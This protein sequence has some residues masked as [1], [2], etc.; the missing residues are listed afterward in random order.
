MGAKMVR[1][2]LNKAAIAAVAL[3]LTAS[4]ASAQECPWWD[5]TCVYTIDPPP[6]DPLPEPLPP[7][8]RSDDP[9]PPV[10]LRSYK[11]EGCTVV[12]ENPL[13]ISYKDANGAWAT[14]TPKCVDSVPTIYADGSVKYNDID[15]YKGDHY[16][17][18]VCADAPSDAPTLKNG[19]MI[20]TQCPANMFCAG[21]EC[22]PPQKVDGCWDSDQVGLSDPKAFMAEFLQLN[23]QIK[24]PGF[25]KYHNPYFDISKP[26]DAKLNPKFKFWV[27]DCKSPQFLNEQSCVTATNN[28]YFSEPKQTTVSCPMGTECQVVAITPAQDITNDA[29]KDPFQPLKT[30]RCMPKP[31][32]CEPPFI[33]ACP[34]LPGCQF[35]KLECPPDPDVCKNIPESD[36]KKKYPASTIFQA[37][38]G[39]WHVDQC[40]SPKQV[41]H[42]FCLGGKADEAITSCPSDTSCANGLCNGQPAP[43]PQ[44]KPADCEDSDITDSNPYGD[45]KIA[46]TIKIKGKWASGDMCKSK[47]IVQQ[48]KCDAKIDVGFS[49][50]SYTCASKDECCDGACFTLIAPQCGDYTDTVSSK[51]GVKGTSKQ[52]TVFD[53]K[54]TCSNDLLAKAACD[55]TGCLGYQFKIEAC[56][57]GKVCQDGLCV[58]KQDPCSASC[59]ALADG[60]EYINT[61]DPLC[62]KMT[63]KNF[64]DAEFLTTYTCGPDSKPVPTLIKCPSGLCDVNKCVDC[65]EVSDIENDLKVKGEVKSTTGNAL[66]FCTNDG[67]VVQVQCL[68]GKYNELA[69]ADCPATDYCLQGV[70]LPKP[71]QCQNDADCTDANVCTMEACVAGKCEQTGQKGIPEETACEKF[72]CN[73]QTGAIESTNQDKCIS[74][75]VCDAS[76]KCV[77]PDPCAGKFVDDYNACTIDKCTNG[78]VTNTQLPVDDGDLCTIDTCVAGMVKNTPMSV[79][80]FDPCT[81]DSCVNGVVKNI[82]SP[83]PVCQDKDNDGIPNDNDNCP[84]V[85]NKTQEDVNT[86]KVG[87]ACELQLTARNVHACATFFATNPTTNATQPQLKCW[88]YNGS[89]QV[90]N[91]KTSLYVAPAAT[92]IDSYGKPVF[93]TSIA[94]GY[95]HSC[96][97]SVKGTSLP[98]RPLCWGSSNLYA[99]GNINGNNLSIATPIPVGMGNASNMGVAAGTSASCALNS[100]GYVYC[101][102]LIIEQQKKNSWAATWMPDYVMSGPNTDLNNV[103]SIAAGGKEICAV[104]KDGT[105]RCWGMTGTQA[106]DTPVTTHYPKPITKPNS[107]TGP[108]T[109]ILKIATSGDHA[110]VLLQDTSVVCWGRATEG[111]L[112]TSQANLYQNTSGLWYG[113][114][115]FVVMDPSAYVSLALTGAVDIAVGQKHSCAVLKNG[116]VTCWGGNASGEL[117]GSPVGGPFGPLTPVAVEGVSGVTQIA[118]GANFTCA[119]VK[120]QSVKCWGNNQFGQLG[121]PPPPACG[122]KQIEADE[123]CDDGNTLSGDGCSSTCQL[124]EVKPVCGNSK[125][126]Y[127]EECDDGNTWGGDGCSAL[128]KKEIPVDPYNPSND[129]YGNP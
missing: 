17:K 46:G 129:P 122:N 19:Q 128:C 74:P 75:L 41:W 119:R 93:A 127:P 97:I 29:A 96:A 9:T 1:V 86:N 43:E 90:G 89:G 61:A 50:K 31:D 103:V 123:V 114:P 98:P 18:P 13:T 82:P 47:K 10:D 33:D 40:A 52:G 78:I 81:T 79:D 48:D 69:P 25:A 113:Y 22:K 87:D 5:Y 58:K 44:D 115:Y 63:T 99:N 77:L 108:M 106:G 53:I 104:L 67:K 30:A 102:G 101:W 125:I 111:Q 95:N 45:L 55:L 71:P 66:D 7:D 84:T 16:L 59:T 21:G 34:T 65:L 42:L 68:N 118:A 23:P 35:T 64:C 73:S 107:L 110:C 15:D 85:Y 14:A 8:A 92:V 70:C 100:D 37:N 20:L 109:G 6:V 112:G 12:A 57:D 24:I 76:K 51:H 38:G 126:E 2:F 26:E 28:L 72:S 124:E 88:G 39:G 32:A 83:D 91:G 94:A 27:D 11:E 116:S 3:L 54:D 105:G 56:P 80:D 49:S 62:P 120:D 117:G 4:A 36:L 60:V 121:V